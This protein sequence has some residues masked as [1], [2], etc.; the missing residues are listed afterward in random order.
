MLHGR[1]Y[2]IN[3]FLV[4]FSFRRIEALLSSGCDSVAKRY[5]LNIS[6][7][8]GLSRRVLIHHEDIGETERAHFGPL[9]HAVI[10]RRQELMLPDVCPCAVVAAAAVRMGMEMY[11][12][13][14]RA[15]HTNHEHVKAFHRFAL[16]QRSMK[17]ASAACLDEESRY[18]PVSQAVDVLLK[19]HGSMMERVQS[20]KDWL[21]DSEETT[22]TD[23]QHIEAL[24]DAA[25]V[26]DSEG[27]EWW[28]C[29]GTLI[30]LLRHGRR[31]GL[32]SKGRL[33]VVDH[34]VDV[35]VG[36]PSH[37]EWTQT[38]FSIA[39]KLSERG[40][41]NCFERYSVSAPQLSDQ[42]YL[43]RGDLFLC[44]RAGPKVTLDIATYIVEGPTA[45]AQK[46]CLPGAPSGS[47]FGC[48]FPQHDGTFRGSRGRL[49]V[50]AIRPLGRCKA[51]HLSVP[52][53]R[54]PLETLRAT[55]M[56]NFTNSCVALPDIKQRRERDLYDSDRDSW[57]SEGLVPE[58]VD[59]LR[60]RA[61]DLERDGYLSMA[62]YCSSSP[63][64]AVAVSGW[65]ESPGKPWA[66]TWREDLQLL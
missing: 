27:L 48:W 26:F 25:A 4:I 61:A 8:L 6:Q 46:Y 3:I 57:L 56:V 49:R 13:E 37:E 66:L 38:R 62:P 41:A 18:W 21:V 16:L 14:N 40:W 12:F 19:A 35:M 30:A 7:F 52:C 31:S 45:H 1:S 33:D 39:R 34:D 60:S 10:E 17:E 9:V 54:K 36:I 24:A 58:D 43:A 23:E 42:Y 28:P 65:R 5:Q 15:A 11:I 59:I 20:M 63:H 53:P 29:R 2:S 44:T 51:G 47:G 55:M 50:S 22:I 32:L 64:Q